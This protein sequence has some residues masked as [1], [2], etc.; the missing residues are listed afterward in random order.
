[1]NFAKIALPLILPI[2]IMG[3]VASIA[4][5]GFLF[6]KE[7]LKP[8]LGKL[9]PIKGF[10]NMFSKK[11][12]VDLFKNFIVIFILAYIGIDFVKENYNEII[13]ANRKFI[14]ANLWS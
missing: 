9:N 13:Q 1:M 7:G 5:T 12:I 2:M 10:R 3:I 8:S 14:F 11:N 6:S 4:Q